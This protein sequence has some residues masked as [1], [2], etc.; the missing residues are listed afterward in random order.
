MDKETYFTPDSILTEAFE[1]IGLL[2]PDVTP[3]QWDSGLRAINY[4][5][6][7]MGN[8]NTQFDFLWNR[9]LIP[10]NPAQSI[11]PFPTHVQHIKGVNLSSPFNVSGELNKK[12]EFVNGFPQVGWEDLF[13]G[14]NINPIPKNT[15]ITFNFNTPQQILYIK[16]NS[17]TNLAANLIMTMGVRALVDSEEPFYTEPFFIEKLYQGTFY[18][19][20]QSPVVGKGYSIS[21]DKD[22]DLR[23]LAFLKTNQGLQD[24]PIGESSMSDYMS[25]AQ[26]TL[27]NN[28]PSWYVFKKEK[29]PLLI[30][31]SQSTTYN[32]CY[33]LSYGLPYSENLLLTIVPRMPFY[34][35]NYLIARV[36]VNLAKK[37]ALDRVSLL[38]EDSQILLNG[39]SQSQANSAPVSFNYD[40]SIRSFWR[41]N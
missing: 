14:N 30:F 41:N 28:I 17:S 21:F 16:I 7:E 22:I 15:Q 13:K 33:L 37:F 2:A 18:F 8:A 35:V 25:M 11:Y 24:R 10:L 38:A 9:T 19:C 23:E 26:K 5:L 39:L 40:Y 31:P 12:G 20:I 36:S 4:E 6:W 34:A 3:L 29:T 1:R 27:P 32:S